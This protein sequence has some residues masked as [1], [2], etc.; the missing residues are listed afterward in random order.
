[1]V[2]DS[3]ATGFVGATRPRHA[4]TA[5]RDGSR[6]HPHRHA[7]QGARRRERRLHVGPQGNHR[8]GCGSARGRTCS[9]T[10]F[11]RSSPRRACACSTCSKPTTSCA[12]R[13]WDNAR[14]FREAD[15]R[16]RASTSCP[17]SIRSF[18]SC[19]AMRSSPSDFARPAARSRCV[20]HRLFLPGRAAGQ[21]AHPHADVGRAHVCD[22]SD[23]R[24]RRR[25]ALPAS[26][27]QRRA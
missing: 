10:A 12:Q 26:S 24:A 11:R 25:R 14:F 5:R 23:L 8:A 27:A 17:A 16:R 6:R 22:A 3:H 4:R 20:C 1:M 13:L 15:D 2:D 19:W 21:G 18:R 9:P 7:R